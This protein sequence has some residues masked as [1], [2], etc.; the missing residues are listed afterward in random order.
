MDMIF[1]LFLFIFGELSSMY[2]SWRRETYLG[3][4]F[5]W[6]VSIFGFTDNLLAPDFDKEL[7]CTSN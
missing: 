3:D 6:K 5:V 7:L 1:V 2:A 4:I